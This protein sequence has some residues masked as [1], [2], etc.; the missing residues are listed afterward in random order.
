MHPRYRASV[1]ALVV[2]NMAA[3]RE[4]PGRGVFVRDQ[5]AALRAHPGVA[6]EL[7][8]FTPGA[9]SYPLAARTLR[10][11][12]DG[13][14]LD[15]VHAHFGLTAW[16]TLALRGPRHA[17]TLHGTD[18]R[19][20][21][22]RRLTLAALP[23]MDLVAAA[24]REL[25]DELGPLDRPVAVLPCGVALDRFRPIPRDAARMALG[26]D[27]NSPCLLFPAD[28][29]RPGKRFD[30][31]GEL[32]GNVRL[33]TLGATAPDH[34]T[35]AINAANAVLVPSDAEGFGLAVLEA[36]ACDVPVLATPVGIHA[37]ALEGIEGTLCA[38]Y[39]RAR[40]AA[41]L[42]PLLADPDPRVPGRERAAEY[43]SEVMAGRVVEAWRQLAAGEPLP[44]GM[45][46]GGPLASP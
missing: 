28:P 12:F 30:R 24:S 33:I 19:H 29:A 16:P 44:A 31:A 8:E 4:R 1:R 14:R 37:E 7:F 23:R 41:A 43:S 15:V 32:A 26:L 22:S 9:L 13:A 27:R 42:A 21:R 20:A 35:L 45:L 2:S 38:P 40:W 11:R 10:R 39:E 5:V 18:V 17:V 25:A 36:L 34:V 46:P 3:S 6:V